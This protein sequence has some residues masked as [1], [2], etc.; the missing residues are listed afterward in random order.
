MIA[1][2]ADIPY[3]YYVDQTNV[4]MK[5]NSFSCKPIVPTTD[6]EQIVKHHGDQLAR[7]S[8]QVAL[9]QR[10]TS[11]PEWMSMSKA[12]AHPALSGR[13]TS[14]QIRDRVLR[15]ISDPVTAPLSVNI[16]Y[17]IIPAGDLRKYVVN[18]IAIGQYLKD[19]ATNIY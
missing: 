2:D 14:R 17:Q 15:S 1:K 7:L 18:P 11:E 4:A 10:P 16:H 19:F 13:L 12:A 8:A 5:K 3:D 9:L 6:L